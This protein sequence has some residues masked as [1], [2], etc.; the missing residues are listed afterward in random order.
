MIDSAL[1][2][3][4]VTIVLIGTYTASR[5]YVNYEI[6]QSHLRGNGLLGI[7]IHN[8]N[9]HHGH[10]SESG[11]NPFDNHRDS[12]SGRLLS[13]I[14]PTYW[15]YKDHGRDNLSGWIERA[16]VAAGH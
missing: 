12:A 3:T 7:Y 16:A 2:G 1:V 11:P 10:A 9:D 15:W 6:E 14:Y 5:R 13:G 8:L 4:S